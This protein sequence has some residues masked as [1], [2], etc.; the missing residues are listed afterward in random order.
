M[1]DTSNNLV[2]TSNVV[3]ND[4]MYFDLRKDD[5]YYVCNINIE[6]LK[7]MKIRKRIRKLFNS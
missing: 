2:N 3:L 6:K 4:V 1:I 7:E 5:G